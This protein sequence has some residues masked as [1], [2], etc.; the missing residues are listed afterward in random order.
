MY[1]TIFF[2]LKNERKA[3]RLKH[4]PLKIFRHLIPIE[5]KEFQPKTMPEVIVKELSGTWLNSGS[6]S[7]ASLPSKVFSYNANGTYLSELLISEEKGVPEN[8]DTA[9]Y[10]R[11]PSLSEKSLSCAV[12]VFL[13]KWCLFSLFFF[14]GFNLGE[15]NWS[16]GV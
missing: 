16:N 5:I 1:V 3:E 12:I 14:F 15:Q 2:L 6:P 8:E 13:F 7:L 4:S 9:G 10:K 11:R